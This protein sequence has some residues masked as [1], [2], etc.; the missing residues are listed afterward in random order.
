MAVSVALEN[1][2]IE[3]QPGEQAACNVLV[4]NTGLVVDR[5]LLDVLGDASGWAKVEPAELSLMPG[6]SESARVVFCPPRASRPRAGEFP[7]AL[8]AYSREDP[9][10]SV[11]VEGAVTL[12]S[13]IDVRAELVPRTSHARRRARHRLIVENRGNTGTD[14]QAS[15]ADPDNLL[16]FRTRPD[17]FFVPPGTATFVRLAAEP[18]RR[19]LKGPSKSLPFQ[20]YVAS[21]QA[22]PVTVEGAVL[23]RQIMPEWLLPLLAIATIAAAALV[24]LWLLVFKPEVQS[25]AVQAVAA[26]TRGLASAAAKASQAAGAADQAAAKADAAAAPG[27]AAGSN[28]P[29]GSGSGG[30]GSG[31]SGSGGSGSGARARGS[32]SPSSRGAPTS[33]ASPAASPVSTLMASD[34]APGKTGTYPYKLAADQA[35]TVSDVL[36]ENPA[37]DNG[38][39]NI[40]SG[41]SPLFEFALADFRDLD[42]HFVQ[43]LEFSSSHPLEIVVA[44]ANTGSAR[45]TPALSFS[46]TVTTSAKPKK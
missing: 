40:Q 8:R 39:M 31:G 19:F 35:L 38:T 32:P 2:S 28:P 14:L 9:E 29:G 27:S 41:A 26:Q 10:G 18:R 30:S 45:C 37:G 15:A 34:V 25:A 1:A 44:C 36:L 20:V 6:T 7:F 24:A 33:V 13:F 5:I 21:G 3:A 17:R 11:I 46:G 12:G 42:Y 4:R 43:P 16:E 23:Q 22:E